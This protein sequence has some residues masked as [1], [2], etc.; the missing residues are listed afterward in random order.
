MYATASLMLLRSSVV[1][2]SGS[3]FLSVVE[4]GGGEPG[5]PGGDSAIGVAAPR[6]VPGAMAATCEAYII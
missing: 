4:G 3:G 6:C 2:E 1:A 5:K